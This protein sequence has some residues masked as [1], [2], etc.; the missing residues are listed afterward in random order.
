MTCGSLEEQVSQRKM[1]KSTEVAGRL[2]EWRAGGE[3]HKPTHQGSEDPHDDVSSLL[4]Q[5]SRRIR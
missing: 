1:L 4:V 3:G 2:L 5:P